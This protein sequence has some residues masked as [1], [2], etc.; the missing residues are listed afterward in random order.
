M[1][2]VAFETAAPASERPQTARLHQTTLT[3]SVL[4][5][6]ATLPR[7]RLCAVMLKFCRLLWHWNTKEFYIMWCLILAVACVS[8]GFC[9][10]L[11]ESGAEC[12]MSNWCPR[13]PELVS[14]KGPRAAQR[15]GKQKS[16]L[17][18]Q[19]SVAVRTYSESQIHRPLEPFKTYCVDVC[20]GCPLPSP[21][22]D[23]PTH[24]YWHSLHTF[25]HGA[26]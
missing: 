3:A 10:Y 4:S 23:I 24:T 20:G 5:H 9:N 12:M 18:G 13:S 7:Y 22:P 25:Q 11:Y 15:G 16:A 17:W 21:R 14:W 6:V 26:M 8:I 19:R 1:P 2:L